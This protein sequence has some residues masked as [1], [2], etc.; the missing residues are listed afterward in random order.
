MLPPTSVAC[1]FALIGHAGG[2]GARLVYLLKA[3][4]VGGEITEYHARAM[5]CHW[6]KANWSRL[7]ASRRTV[8]PSEIIADWRNA[9]S[10][11]AVKRKANAF[12]RAQRRSAE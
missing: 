2:S 6:S 12:N 1:P 9:P 4:A 8:M 11:A 5:A 10:I 7:Y 3:I